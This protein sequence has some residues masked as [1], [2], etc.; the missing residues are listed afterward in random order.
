MK[1]WVLWVLR[2]KAFWKKEWKYGVT[3]LAGGVLVCVLW[4]GVYAANIQ[5]GI[6]DGVV[7]FHVLANSDTTADQ[8]LKLDVRDAVLSAFGEKLEGCSS[9][10]ESMALLAAYKEEIRQTAAAE[11]ARQ[12]YDYPVSVSLVRED[13]P[14]KTYGNLVFPAGVYDAVRIEIGEAKGHNWWCVLYPNLCFID[15]VHAVV[16]EDGKKELQEVLT[17]EEYDLVTSDA[18]VK[19]RWFFFPEK[20]D[21]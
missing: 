4:S 6:A 18:K 1:T 2:M 8:N 14:E 9:K 15:A 10:G 3:A 12:G 11:I 20:D 16:P 13:F 21:K 5:R 19:V 17:E 7:R